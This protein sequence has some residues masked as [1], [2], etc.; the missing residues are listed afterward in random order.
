MKD[1]NNKNCFITG[2]ASGIGR[3]FAIALA[4]EGMNLFISDVNMEDL[5][6]VKE[7]IER[8]GVRVYAK[9]CDVSNFSDWEKIGKDFFTKVKEL[10]LLINNA[11]IAIGGD[12]LELELE[13]WKY[14]LD[15]NL[16]GIIHSLKVFLPH[17]YNRRSGHIVNVASGA[18]IFG[19]AEP[20]PY[21][22]SKFAVVG[23]SEALFGQLYNRNI[24]VSVVIPTYIRTNIFSN[25]KLK[26]SKKL[27]ERFG[28]EKIE[29][30]YRSLLDLISN[31]AMSPD[32]AVKRYI[33]G[34]KNNQLFVYDMKSVLGPLSLK[35][36]PQLY[37]KFL[38]EYNK[39]S[40]DTIKGHYLKFGIDLDNYS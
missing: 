9:K 18:G 12:L 1:L 3:S 16:W 39:N 28:K 4:K 30:I 31:S 14:V 23:L 10:D 34:I 38:I 25:S 5:S 35:G 21:I 17:M 11:G 8:T 24:K 33:R 22:T 13:D 40:I 20:L 26:F 15:I 29:N 37:E 6:R 19:S 7:E 27:I 32:K 2:A 36:N